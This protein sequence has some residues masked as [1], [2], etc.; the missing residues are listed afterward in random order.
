VDLVDIFNHCAV[1]AP[2]CSKLWQVSW[3]NKA[4]GLLLRTGK[5]Y[6]IITAIV[7]PDKV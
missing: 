5:E 2:R 6:R 4:F 7:S 1:E 3:P